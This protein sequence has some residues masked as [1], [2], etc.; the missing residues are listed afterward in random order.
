MAK[1]KAPL[2]S[3]GATQQLGKALVFFG[4][5]GLDVVRE[6]VIPANPRTSAQTTQRGY[7]TEAVQQIHNA[8]ARENN[9]LV[10]DDKTAYGLW[11]SIVQAATTWFNQAV[12]NY[13]DQK[14]AGKKPALF[15]GGATTPGASELAVEIYSGDI[16]PTG[17]TTADFYYG[18]SKTAM[19]NKE[20][21]DIDGA[22]NKASATISGLT[23]G[24]KYF[25]QLRA[26]TPAYDGA[27]S[28]VYYGVAG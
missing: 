2:M 7:V 10:E 13:V 4:W 28:G 14:V 19:I 1:L 20:S 23:S 26:V 5:K 8:Q 12:R 16:V 3:L 18:T 27:R 21:A 24:V 25:W 11:A 6:Y 9:P 22:L 15:Y 17:I